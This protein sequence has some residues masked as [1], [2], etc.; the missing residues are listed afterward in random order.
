MKGITYNTPPYI[1]EPTAHA[2]ETVPTIS[3]KLAMEGSPIT[4]VHGRL[5][6]LPTAETQLYD[7]ATAS[8]PYSTASD[9]VATP[10]KATKSLHK[11]A[12]TSD[13][14]SIPQSLLSEPLPRNYKPLL[15]SPG[16]YCNALH[17]TPVGYLPDSSQC[18]LE[19]RNTSTSPL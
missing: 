14:I 16:P 7:F 18:S 6:L 8:R 3:A 9:E 17:D 5:F 10:R 2:T 15:P 12:S 19:K 13:S 1:Y 4:P 11:S